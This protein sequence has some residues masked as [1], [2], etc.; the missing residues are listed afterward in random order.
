MQDCVLM[1]RSFSSSSSIFWHLRM[2]STE[3][4]SI[5]RDVIG[6]LIEQQVGK[7]KRH[8]ELPLCIEE[9]GE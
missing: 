8:K 7:S 1:L 3:E 2:F 9:E 4:E 6:E 5:G